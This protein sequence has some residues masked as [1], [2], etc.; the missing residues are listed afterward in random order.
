[1]EQPLNWIVKSI[2]SNTNLELEGEN[3]Y[4]YDAFIDKQIAAGNIIKHSQ[5]DFTA[6]G[7]AA[8]INK[9]LLES[10][11]E[12]QIISVNAVDPRVTT[13]VKGQGLYFI[14]LKNG[15]AHQLMIVTWSFNAI[16]FFDF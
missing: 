4:E 1:M 7:L 6:E 9:K 11:S 2:H 14:V 3:F 16:T 15:V 12:Y 5:Y 10:N 13:K 8:V